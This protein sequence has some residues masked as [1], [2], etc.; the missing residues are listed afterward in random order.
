MRRHGRTMPSFLRSRRFTPRTVAIAA[1]TAVALFAVAALVITQCSGT[2][3]SSDAAARKTAA[4]TLAIR[5]LPSGKLFVV[6]SSSIDGFDFSGSMAEGATE[7]D[8]RVVELTDTARLDQQV[9][10]PN[11]KRV[12][13]WANGSVY[14]QPQGE[15]APPELGDRWVKDYTPQNLIGLRPGP[16]VLVDLLARY[17]LEW[18]PIV[19]GADNLGDSLVPFTTTSAIHYQAHIVYEEAA[20]L[21]A[22]IAPPVPSPIRD[23]AS[24]FAAPK[25]SQYPSAF[26]PRP[27]EL[28]Q[29]TYTME[30]WVTSAGELVGIRVNADLAALGPK[31]I[32]QSVTAVIADPRSNVSIDVPSPNKV[33]TQQQLNQ[34]IS[35]NGH[36][37]PSTLITP[38]ATSSTTIETTGPG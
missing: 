11:A 6:A 34:E 19:E 28:D 25:T 12:E 8:S 30:V 35:A 24:Q 15:W 14:V 37:D 4:T 29:V 31:W 21:A 1:T 9:T 10:Y 3:S 36:Q 22:A 17:P 26:A 13:I 23:L 27:I 32:S 7:T 18:N 5:S 38:Q 33:I 2:T 20:F 16:A